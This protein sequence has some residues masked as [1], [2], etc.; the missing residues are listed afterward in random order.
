MEKLTC[1]LLLNLP[2]SALGGI[3][4]LSFTTTPRFRGIK[5]LPSGF[6]FVFTSPTTALS[7]RHGAWFYVDKSL[8]LSSSLCIKKWDSSREELLPEDDEA[9]I[10]RWRANIGS[11]WKDGL[12]PYRQHTNTGANDMSENIIEVS[13]AW[14]NLTSHITAPLLA[15]ITGGPRDHWNLTSAS[16]ASADID[17]IP[18]LS[19]LE[20]IIQPE[21]ELKFL[22]INLKQTWREGATGRERTNAARDRSWALS[23]LIA[24]NC[25]DQNETEVLGELQFSFLMV[26]T[27]NNN[28]CLEQWKRILGLLL[29]CRTAVVTRSKLFATLFR[30][31]RLQLEQ[32]REDDGDL[33]DLSDEGGTLLRKWLRDF[34]R[35]IEQESNTE[36]EDVLDE[37][38]ALEYFIRTEFG[39][40]LHRDFVRNGMLELEDGEKVEMDIEG[41][42]DIDER[43]EYAPTIVELTADQMMNFGGDPS[44]TSV[45]HGHFSQTDEKG[46]QENEEERKFVN[47]NPEEGDVEL[48]DLESMDNRY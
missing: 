2:Q 30:T 26:L 41:D 20:S 17:H 21:K 46:A 28:S 45:M 1:V 8:T 11:F 34:K 18:G 3:D 31:L 32:T 23:E 16:S 14:K 7:V 33:F 9:S 6:H 15:R 27:L 22:P 13:H 24:G 36:I 38:E 42:D 37:L 19:G 10:L 43:G 35:G 4:L 40:D 44:L 25:A 48:S 5:N 39:W 12:T 47:D 29:T